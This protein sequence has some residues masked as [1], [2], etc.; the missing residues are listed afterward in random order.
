MSDSRVGSS[1]VIGEEV[2]RVLDRLEEL[3][4]AARVVQKALDASGSAF[5]T[6]EELQ[7]ILRGDPGATADVLR[8]ANS[9]YFGV[10]AQIRTLAMAI[11]VVGHARLRT[12]LRH[13]VVSKVFEML[14]VDSKLARQARDKALAA[15]VACH[16]LARKLKR[17][18]SDELL[19]SGL[20]HNI[21]EIALLSELPEQYQKIIALSQTMPR[22]MAEI[23]VLGVDHQAISSRLL[24]SWDF[25]DI[26]VA[27]AEHWNTPRHSSLN[28]SFYPSLEIV[29]AG[30]SLAESWLEGFD[31]AAVIQ[32]LAASR[33][34]LAQS[35]PHLLIEVYGRIEP[36]LQKLSRSLL[37]VAAD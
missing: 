11:T 6:N 19:L 36:E 14:P 27:A 5:C 16:E 17:P 22:R 37:D 7:R 12:L 20:L 33:V 24:R 1:G 32:R 25:P 21:G 10:S 29:H 18:D 35:S 4:A 13:L 15:G 31:D 9:P 30:A 2:R 26:F 8:I 23:A 34:V 28:P 3:P